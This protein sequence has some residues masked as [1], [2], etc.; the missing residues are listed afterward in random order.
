V[1]EVATTGQDTQYIQDD[2]K[3]HEKKEKFMRWIMFSKYHAGPRRLREGW[4]PVL[5]HPG[6]EGYN[7]GA[8][9]AILSRMKRAP[10]LFGYPNCFTPP[11][12]GWDAGCWV[13]NQLNSKQTVYGYYQGGGKRLLRYCT[14]SL[15]LSLQQRK[16][17]LKTFSVSPNQV[18]HVPRV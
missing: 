16:H 6:P 10:L 9:T 14:N 3:T 12:M 8:A 13:W 17:T 1:A 5:G 4:V 7:G 18:G 11:T 2:Q 15:D